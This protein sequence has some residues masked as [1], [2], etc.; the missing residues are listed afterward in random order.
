MW[1]VIIEFEWLDD[2][3]DTS[4]WVVGLIAFDVYSVE[5]KIDELVR[6]FKFVTDTVVTETVV[7]LIDG[8]TVEVTFEY[9][10]T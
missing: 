4:D 5:L 7:D 9:V 3:D 2:V 8:N 6:E 10:S 1:T